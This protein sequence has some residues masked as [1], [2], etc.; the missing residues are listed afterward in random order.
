MMRANIDSNPDPEAMNVSVGLSL[1]EGRAIPR[2]SWYE[3][4]IRRFIY[5][6]CQIQDLRSIPPRATNLISVTLSN[7]RSPKSTSEQRSAKRLFQNSCGFLNQ[8]VSQWF[9]Y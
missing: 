8:R 5:S 3:V 4:A 7:A 2:S 1:K 6:R 9:F